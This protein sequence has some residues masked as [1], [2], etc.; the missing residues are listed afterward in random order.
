[1]AKPDHPQLEMYRHLNY[2]QS[3][4]FGEFIRFW[5]WIRVEKEKKNFQ[6]VEGISKYAKT[7]VK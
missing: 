3:K 4:A 6:T 1:M 2:S 7:P 5:V